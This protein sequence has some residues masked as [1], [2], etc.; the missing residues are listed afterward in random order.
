[1]V[2]ATGLNW[3]GIPNYYGTVLEIKYPE[4]DTVN[5]IVLDACG[6]CSWDNRIDL[7][8]YSPQGSHDITGIEYRIVR[9]GFK[10]DEDNSGSEII[11][12]DAQTAE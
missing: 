5:A 2:L 10:E 1:E 4:G 7:W 8:V 9:D 6:A 11:A 3:R 12:A